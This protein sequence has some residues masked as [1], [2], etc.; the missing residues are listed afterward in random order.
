MVQSLTPAQKGNSDDHYSRLK[1]YYLIPSQTQM[2]YNL[3]TT[4]I[5]LAPAPSVPE[6]ND[7]KG[8]HLL[9]LNSG[10]LVCLLDILTQKKFTE[11]CDITTKKSIYL[12]ILYILKR[13]LVILGFY[14]LKNSTSS[15]YNES[16]EQ[17]LSLKPITTIF[18]EQNIPIALE[19]EIALLLLKYAQEYPIPKS[20]FLQYDHII[21]LIR[22]IWCLASNNKQ[23]LFDANLKKDFTAIHKTFK[24]DNVSI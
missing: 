7:L 10:G 11:H 6:T 22:L 15:I 23:I 21:E 18:N 16:L 17:I 14:Q 3:K 1:T 8:I 9:F 19:K 5:K 24:Q 20:S 2:L 12:I 4:F 13:F